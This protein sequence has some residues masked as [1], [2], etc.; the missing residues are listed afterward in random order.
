MVQNKYALEISYFGSREVDGWLVPCRET[1]LRVVKFAPMEFCS[2][3]GETQYA[4]FLASYRAE[5]QNLCSLVLTFVRGARPGLNLDR[6]AL[7]RVLLDW[8]T[9]QWRGHREYPIPVVPNQEDDGPPGTVILT[10]LSEI[11]ADTS[12]AWTQPFRFQ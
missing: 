12:R 2:Y 7:Y 4:D 10:L 11:I 1:A 8:N 9:W 5:Y 3:R 6:D